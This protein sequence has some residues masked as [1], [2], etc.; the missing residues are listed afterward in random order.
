[1]I[2]NARLCLCGDSV[3]DRSPVG[4]A[5]TGTAT[6]ATINGGDLK[7][8]TV[9]SAITASV[10]TGG[11]AY[12][13]ASFGGIWRWC[14]TWEDWSGYVTE[15]GGTLTIQAGLV[16]TRLTYTATPQ[17]PAA[18]LARAE[19]YDRPLFAAGVRMLLGGTS[20]A[21]RDLSVDRTSG[22]VAIPTGDGVTLIRDGIRTAYYDAPQAG[23]TT[24]DC[25]VASLC[26]GS[27][28]IGT[29]AEAA[30]IQ[31]AL[32]GK[33]AILAG[34]SRP[35]ISSRESVARGV[36]VDATPLDLSPRRLVG[37]RETL[38]VRS[39]TVGR[40]VGPTAVERARCVR[41]S[42]VYR[43]AGG[44]VTQQ[45]AVQTI[46]TDVVV[47]TGSTVT[48]AVDTTAQSVAVRVTGGSVTLATNPIAT[49]NGSATLT[50]THASHG[51]SS[52][53]TVTIGG[54]A[55][56]IGGIAAAS[57]NGT[58]TITVTGAGTYTVTAGASATSS[59]AGGTACTITPRI[60]WES[61]IT[62]TPLS[63]EAVYAQ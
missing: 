15:S 56:A 21:C 14:T 30:L 50:V 41:E 16:F 42:L 51:L 61:A 22:Q 35:V 2:G 23:M 54:V 44:N 34:G 52:G 62:I 58:R 6:F 12:G 25:K 11:M 29:A 8:T 7:A 57:I 20:N 28:V 17:L 33:D 45:G 63:E 43:D 9:T 19:A 37:Q 31:D 49:T 4:T 39:V 46:G 38:V 59:A 10:T 32:P 3:T 53:D 5:V 60:R 48:H 1:M 13:W 27:L 36:T 18:Q 40:S 47:L 55:S 24:D 26:A